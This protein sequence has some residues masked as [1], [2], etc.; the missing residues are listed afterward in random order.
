[1]DLYCVID[2]G[3]NTVR[4]VIYQLREGVLQPILNN[5][6]AA[7]LASYVDKQSRMTPD[8]VR[9][10][11]NILR[12]FQQILSLLPDCQ[13]FPFATAS[14]RNIQNTDYVLQEIE[15][16][17][18]MRV[19][20]LSGYEE[21][22]LDYRGATRALDRSSGLMADIGGGSTE[23]IFFKEGRVQAAE[24]LPFGS[25]NLYRR[26][27]TGLFPTGSELK[28]MES[29]LKSAL[30]LTLPDTGEFVSQPLYAIGGSARGLLSLYQQWDE[31][32]GACLEYPC[33]FFR[34][35]LSRSEKK[36]KKL[37][38]QILK[39][40][41]DR[42][43]TLVPGALILHVVAKTYGSS[44]VLTSRYGVREG[45]LDFMLESQK[46]GAEHHG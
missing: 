31:P 46:N 19:R 18:G 35:V 6:V 40:A 36:P 20:V 29:E 17:C 41:P 8:G 7:G 26:F 25:L 10:L 32:N 28:E 43:H 16:M 2:I 3:S 45:Y 22:M 34:E 11:V 5:K 23:L 9:K 44:T 38:R 12:D 14:L 4:L 30:T 37:L 33:T 27:C 15:K 39:I 42:V 13:V 24:S 21:A 1:M